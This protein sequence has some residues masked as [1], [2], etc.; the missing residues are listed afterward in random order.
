LVA[1][2]CIAAGGLVWGFASIAA[3]VD[4][5]EMEAAGRPYC[6]QVPTGATRPL[7]PSYRRVRSRIEL[8]A[9]W[10][11]APSGEPFFPHWAFHAVLAIDGGDGGLRLWNWSYRSRAFRPISDQARTALQEAP[12][13]P[14]CQPLPH[15]ARNLPM[16]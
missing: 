13:G 4:A 8:N 5:A 14:F 11:H 3:I 7:D 10:M 1:I 12:L 16:F 2:L 9:F 6:L 15:F